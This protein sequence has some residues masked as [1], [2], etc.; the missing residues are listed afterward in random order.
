MKNLVNYE[1]FVQQHSN[2]LMTKE[3]CVIGVNEE[4]GEIAGFY[5]KY[6]LKKNKNLKKD[7]LKKKDMA[8]EIGDVLFYLTRLAKLYGWSLSDIMDMNIEKLERE[9]QEKMEKKEE[10]GTE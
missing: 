6:H 1:K 4:A 9:E 8:E 5:K 7:P 10:N 3:Y 2:K